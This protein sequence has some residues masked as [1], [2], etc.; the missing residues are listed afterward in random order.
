M[1]FFNTTT[2]GERPDMEI[3]FAPFA[4]AA[5]D[6]RGEAHYRGAV[7]FIPSLCRPKARGRVSLRSLDAHDLPRVDMSMLADEDLPVLIAGC[8]MA[9]RVMHAE[10]FKPYVIDERLPGP[11]VQGDDEWIDFLRAGV[12]G[13]NHLVGTCK[14]GLDAQAVVSP[15]LR[16]HGVENLRVMD[17]S[18]IPNLISAHTNAIAFVIG[19]KGSDLL[20]GR[21]ADMI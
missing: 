14:M 9:R 18:I 3:L 7:N 12:F 17:A 21:P 11:D 10:A 1:A 20:L 15:E 19:E 16:V 8:R 4:F 13:G 2:P 6:R 5:I